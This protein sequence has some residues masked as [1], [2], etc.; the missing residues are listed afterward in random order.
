MYDLTSSGNMGASSLLTGLLRWWWVILLTV[1]VGAATSF[2]FT[3]QQGE[4]F[5]AETTLV[6]G[7]APGLQDPRQIVDSLD[8]LDRR[9]V[10]ATF[11]LLPQ[12]RRVKELARQ[13]LRL[14][15]AQIE[16]HMVSTAVLPDSNVLA[17]RVEGPDPNLATAFA[18]AIAQQAIASTGEVYS[19][20]GMKVLDPAGEPTASSQA[21][22][23]RRIVAGALG[24]LL[25]GVFAAFLLEMLRRR[26]AARAARAFR[27]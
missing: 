22:A 10:V 5:R 21:G 13:Q 16:D 25:I 1:L 9:S 23:G 6:L 11:A 15:D 26:R 20:Y 17:V 4:R 7:P 18:N 27:T 14:S 8:T 19:I 3:Q 2:Y 24:G 12:S